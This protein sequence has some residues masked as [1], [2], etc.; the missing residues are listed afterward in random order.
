MEKKALDSFNNRILAEAASRY[1]T[2][3]DRLRLIADSESL[4][5]EFEVNGSGYILKILHDSHRNIDQIKGEIDWINFLIAHN[6]PAAGV[7]TSRRGNEI[8]I[9][10]GEDMQFYAVAFEKAPGRPV[11]PSDWTDNFIDHWG[12]MTGLMHALAKQY[13]PSNKSIRRPFWHEEYSFV[14]AADVL[15][16]QPL[17][18]EKHLEMVERL[19]SLPTDIDSFGL[20]HSDFEDENMYINDGRLI[21]FDF[22]ESQYKWYIYD[23]AAILRESTWRLPACRRTDDPCSESFLKTFMQ[24]YNRANKLDRFWL[25]EL[26]FFLRLRETVVYIYY[27]GKVDLMKLNEEIRRAIQIMRRRIENGVPLPDIKYKE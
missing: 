25:E 5:Y 24:G 20:I 16:D 9:V 1:N 14:A 22:D 18:L 13:R 19:S 2:S 21:A 17:V 6:F 8:E 26:S 11:K 27:M 15:A 12:E 4:V 7:V 3:P 10:E 23:I